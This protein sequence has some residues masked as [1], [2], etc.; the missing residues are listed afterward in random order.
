M[1]AAEQRIRLDLNSPVLFRLQPEEL[2]HVM[3]ALRRLRELDWSGLY[4]HPGFRW[5]AIEHPRVGGGGKVYWLRLSQRIRAV[6]FRDGNFLRLV[7]L[8]PDH[9]S[10]YERNVTI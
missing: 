2:K 7:S 8:H 6:G 1:A 5:E 4:R 10:A 3:S 9:D